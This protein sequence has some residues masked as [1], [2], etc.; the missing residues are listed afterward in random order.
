MLINEKE[1]DEE[2]GEFVLNFFREKVREVL[3][4]EHFEV[5][6][7]L[8]LQGKSWQ[9]ICNKSLLATGVQLE[10]SFGLRSMM[11]RGLTTENRMGKTKL[12]KRL[13]SALEDALSEVRL[14]V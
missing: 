4:R 11:F 2:Q 5:H 14:C 9:N 13:V 3:L 12:F 1:L 7:D 10:I 8:R 6:E